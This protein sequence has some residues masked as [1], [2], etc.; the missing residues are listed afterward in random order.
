MAYIVLIGEETENLAAVHSLISGF[1][2]EISEIVKPD[3]ALNNL[4][5][6]KT[7]DLCIFDLTCGKPEISITT[8]KSVSDNFAL[9]VLF[10]ISPDA[11]ISLVRKAL[12][13]CPGGFIVQPVDPL[14]LRVTIET[15]LMHQIEKQALRESE[16]KY[17]AIVE[18]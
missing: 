3:I 4:L 7:S 11:D 5:T 13:T 14:Q 18:N 16:D 1:G 8:A 12:M 6:V 10:V 9:P 17:R 15:A 2:Y